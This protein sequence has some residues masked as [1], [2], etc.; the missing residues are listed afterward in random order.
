MCHMI[1]TYLEVKSREQVCT[2]M[3]S[4]I[5]VDHL[6]SGALFDISI[7]ASASRDNK[8]HDAFYHLHFYS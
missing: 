2:A 3:Q 1:Q 5:N 7:Y 4:Y 6:I 8:Y